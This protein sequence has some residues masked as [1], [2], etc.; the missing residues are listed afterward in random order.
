MTNAKSIANAQNEAAFRFLIVFNFI[1]FTGT[2]RP[3]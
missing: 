3:A 2:G 1:S